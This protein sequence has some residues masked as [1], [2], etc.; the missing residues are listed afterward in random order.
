M[1]TTVSNVI[2]GYACVH[3]QS[4]SLPC[5]RMS[6]DTLYLR[7]YL[8]NEETDMLFIDILTRLSIALPED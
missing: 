2:F 5:V 6:Y 3:K 4:L 7:N 8:L 1:T